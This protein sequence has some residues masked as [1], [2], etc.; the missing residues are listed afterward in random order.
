[1]NSSAKKGIFAALGLILAAFFILPFFIGQYAK[2]Q[3][4]QII[5]QT[6][7]P[8]TIHT[9]IL[10]YHLGWL[11]SDIK[12]KIHLENYSQTDLIGDVRIYHGPLLCLNDQFHQRIWYIGPFA[13][14]GNFKVNDAGLNSLRENELPPEIYLIIRQDFRAN[15]FVDFHTP[16]LLLNNGGTQISIGSIDFRLMHSANHKHTL[17]NALF[18]E[19]KIDSP[20]LMSRLDL[21]FAALQMKLLRNDDNSWTSSS[22]IEV[23]N[24]TFFDRLGRAEFQNIILSNEADSQNSKGLFGLG[25]HVDKIIM[26]QETSGPLNIQVY[27]RNFFDNDFTHFMNAQKFI[28][29]MDLAA[30]LRLQALNPF[31]AATLQG[32]TAHIDS[33]TLKLSDGSSLIFEGNFAFPQI[34][35]NIHPLPLVSDMF[36]QSFLDFKL[37]VPESALKLTSAQANLL[38][39]TL[40]SFFQ[41]GWLVKDNSALTM[42][43]EHTPNGFLM[44]SK[45]WM[46]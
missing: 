37:T 4:T 30:D 29:E 25:L 42:R 26:G 1:M 43:I 45:P 7:S 41:Q 46:T 16:T 27:L 38:Q 17:V 11:H 39:A 35:P 44:N 9:E 12:L 6:S 24:A 3:I 2:N 34:N 13:A 40:L 5:N 14:A 19:V 18:N 8:F 36:A 28:C 23:P 32:V 31:I 10:A 15:N 22:Q 20:S 21:Q 33:G